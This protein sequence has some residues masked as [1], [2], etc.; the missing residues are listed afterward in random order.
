MGGPGVDAEPAFGLP[1]NQKVAAEHLEREPKALLHLVAP[2]QG[3]RG[4]ADDERKVDTLPKQEL[5]QHEAGFD[6]L[7]KTDVVGDEEVGAWKRERLLKRG[8]L[9]R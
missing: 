5:L 3:D 8:E 6:R 2:L 9:V 7:T 4:G 1:A